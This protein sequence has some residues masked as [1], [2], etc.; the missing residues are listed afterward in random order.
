MLSELTAVEV[1][2]DSEA[3]VLVVVN[4]CEPLIASVLVALTVPGATLVSFC[5]A[6]GAAAVPPSA[7]SVSWLAVAVR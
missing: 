3:T 2:V 4:N 1:D 7:T 5:A 6:P